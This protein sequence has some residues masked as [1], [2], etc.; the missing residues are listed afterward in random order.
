MLLIQKL[1]REKQTK[2]PHT[3]WFL[4]P[5][6]DRVWCQPVKQQPLTGNPG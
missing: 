2:T 4:A 1:Y 6:Q 5:H 3:P